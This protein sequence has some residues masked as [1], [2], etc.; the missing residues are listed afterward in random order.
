M[1]L[2]YWVI[3]AIMLYT[4]LLALTRAVLRHAPDP[5]DLEAGI[6]MFV[7]RR[8]SWAM[9]RL[10]IIDA[11]NIP[12]SGHP[13]PLI[14]VA[15]HTA[16]VDPVLIQASCPFPIRWVMADDMAVSM[17][18]PLW[19]IGQ[20][21]RVDRRR[22]ESMGVREALRHIRSGGVL[23]VFP[24]GHLERPP[25]AVLPFLPGVGLFIQ[26]TGARVLP[27]VIDGAPQIDP[28]WA[29]LWRRSRSTVRALPM[30][31]YTDSE[32][33]ARDIAKDLRRRMIEAT[34]W[35]ENDATPR[36]VGDQWVQVD[37]SG[38]WPDGA[39]PAGT[40]AGPSTP[41]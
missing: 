31:D 24:E 21:I 5:S 29:S 4:A 28:A 6:I 38:R 39:P 13:G 40:P 36:L 3:P 19:D 12:R 9:H 14:V 32:L 8:Y 41:R 17:L 11:D 7:F 18:Q 37:V 23:G 10:R 1:L 2:W 22:N 25:R 30:V 16:G 35:P 34:G 20:V 27:L 15:N 33:S 26:R